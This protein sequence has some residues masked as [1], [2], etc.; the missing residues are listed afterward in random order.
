MDMAT[1]NWLAVLVAGM[2]IIRSG[3]H[4]V[5]TRSLRYSLDV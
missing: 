2:F 4:L 5:F 3:W 1:I